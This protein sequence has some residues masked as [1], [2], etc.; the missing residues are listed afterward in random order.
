MHMST[1]SRLPL[2]LAATVL[3]VGCAAGGVAGA[4]QARRPH[5]AALAAFARPAQA[6][7]PTAGSAAG[8]AGAAHQARNFK[9]GVSAWAFPGV[10]SALAQSGVH[11]YYTWATGP[12]GIS[13]P[14]GVS[15]VPMI[16][17]PGSVTA[18]GLRQA[19]QAGHVLLTFNEPDMGSQS[20][21]TVDQALRLWPQL[22]ATG[23]RLSSPAVAYGGDTP[24]GW[25]D[26][27]LRGAAARHYRVNFIAL[28]WYGGDFTTRDAVSQLRSYLQAVWNR[29]HKAI[30]LTEFALI[31]FGA[32]T[33]FP[34]PQLQSA[35][36]TAATAMLQ[37]LPYVWRYAWFALPSNSTD[38]SVGLFRA[39]AVPTI[40]GQAFKKVD[41]P[42]A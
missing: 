24:G 21:M 20:N 33:A 11:W 2:R 17:G 13:T 18:A 7:R 32:T 34:S 10:R 19:R 26:Q 4:G 28:H 38:G 3:A 12:G 29:Y 25:L 41:A 5:P 16:W 15:F 6:A 1:R 8:A 9:K 40:P 31:R 22:M 30:W 35:F 37:R 42:P 14:R 23:M 39:G 27:F 36:V